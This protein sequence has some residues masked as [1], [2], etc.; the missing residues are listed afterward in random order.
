MPVPSV[1]PKRPDMAHCCPCR[2][3]D[4][5]ALNIADAA[6]LCGAPAG[7]L[8]AHIRHDLLSAKYPTTRP[9]ILREEL[10]R[11]KDF[12]ANGFVPL[13]SPE[14][15]WEDTWLRDRELL[16][17]ASKHDQEF[18]SPNCC[19]CHKSNRL[20][21]TTDEA[22]AAIGV[23]VT[24]IRNLIRDHYIVARYPSSR[25]IVEA[26]QL[27]AYLEYCRNYPP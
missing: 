25:P 2:W 21:Y 6:A 8:R 20:A 19:N 17:R 14:S 10:Y 1:R 15:P 26:S 16:R 24:T 4:R 27:I 22:G 9:V 18:S 3:T 5:I 11:W 23:S 13:Y 7:I 12:Y